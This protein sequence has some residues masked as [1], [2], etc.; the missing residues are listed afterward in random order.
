VPSPAQP[1][2]R[3]V[4]AGLTTAAGLTLAG[5]SGDA[6]PSA[7]GAGDA[8]PVAVDPDQALA[9]R[10]RRDEIA[11]LELV[12]STSAKH[13]SL[14]SRL[15]T[16]ERGHLDH[17]GRLTPGTS[18]S[19]ATRRRRVAPDA[20]RALA[21][22]VAA[23][24]QLARTH[25][26]SALDARSGPLARVIASMSAAAAQQASVLGVSGPG[27]SGSGSTGGGS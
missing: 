13:R 6:D 12:R 17:V 10:A 1:T 25:A 23:E 3:A 26:A 20:A 22:V 21:D 24:R 5:C 18:L 14:R 7:L 11:L 9:R 4:V 8:R 27:A 19:L 15:R 2:R 16:A